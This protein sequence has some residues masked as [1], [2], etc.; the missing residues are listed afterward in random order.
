VDN[1]ILLTTLALNTIVLMRNSQL[2]S[3]APS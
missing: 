3:L 2:V 1:N